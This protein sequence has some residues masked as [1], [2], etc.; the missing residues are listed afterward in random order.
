MTGASDHR[1]ADAAAT[2][3]GLHRHPLRSGVLVGAGAALAALLLPALHRPHLRLVWN[4]SA[5]VPIGLYGIEPVTAP[6]VGDLVAVRPSPALTRYMAERRY[7][8]AGALLV[9]PVAGQ[10]GD[11]FCRNDA[12]VTLNGR[13]VA[14]AL[15]R[16]RIG[17]PLPRWSGC[18]RITRNQLVLIAPAM[19]ASFD[20]RY[21]GAVDRGQVIGRAI[22]LWTWP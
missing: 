10:S 1:A 12:R 8:E 5:S 20:S 19:R 16:D 15:P 6:R 22:P 7:V 4:A 13:G 9:K 14:T 21:F 18:Q 3:T 17:R 2:A 11:I